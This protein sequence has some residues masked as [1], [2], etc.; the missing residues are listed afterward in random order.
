MAY[1]VRRRTARPPGL[2]IFQREQLQ[3]Y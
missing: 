3:P 1:Q 2:E